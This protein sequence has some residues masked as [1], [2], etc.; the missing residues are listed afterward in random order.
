SHR[1]DHGIERDLVW[2]HGAKGV[3]H[4][5]GSNRTTF[6][7]NATNTAPSARVVSAHNDGES[8]RLTDSSL[9]AMSKRAAK[10]TSVRAPR[11]AGSIKSTKYRS[12]ASPATT[13]FPEA[14]TARREPW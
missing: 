6:P 2:H 12:L 13:A 9:P 5:R 1:R 7:S 3:S 14:S 4:C 11:I 8:T 10:E